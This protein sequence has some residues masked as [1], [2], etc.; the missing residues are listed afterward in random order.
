[1]DKVAAYVRVSTEQQANDGSHHRQRETIDEYLHNALEGSPD[2]EWF[3]D[4]AESGQN[5]ERNQYENMMA[6]VDEF[7]AIIVREL[8]RF[9]RSLKKMLNDIEEMEENECAFIS[10]K[11]DQI[12]TSTA[13]GKL[14]FN[15]MGAFNQFWADLARERR[16][17]QIE[18]RRQEGK[19]IGR[20]KK[21]SEDQ[22]DYLADIKEQS[23]VTYSA[24]AA[25]AEEKWNISITRKTIA[26][27]FRQ[28]R[29]E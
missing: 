29:D 28:R 20:P 8:S 1:M 25:I 3:E 11:D 4:I 22:I 12:D 24:L 7:D 2:V 9:G 26:R 16:Y 5:L 15:I 6:R 21:L 17:E 14:L 19:T 23:D 10:I 18:R 13:Q 27:Y